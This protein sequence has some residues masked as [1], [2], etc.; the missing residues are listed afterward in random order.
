M[1]VLMK[2]LMKG[3]GVFD[4][5]LDFLTYLAGVLLVLIVLF[6]GTEVMS[7]LLLNRSQIWVMEFSE[8]F[9]LYITFLAT[10]WVLRREGHVRME[11][12]L[13]RLKPRA[14]ALLNTVTFTVS[15][16]L[17]LVIAWYGAEITWDMFQRGVPRATMLETPMAPLLAIIVVGHFLLFV[18]FLRGAYGYLRRWRVSRDQEQS[19]PKRVKVVDKPILNR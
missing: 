14:Q 15:A 12:L 17:C 7:R 8:H 18:Q 11:F 16:M 2:L 1:K 3:T 19:L 9:L 10:A 6:I 13:T 4:R 5:T